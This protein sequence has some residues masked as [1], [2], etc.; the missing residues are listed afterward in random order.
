MIET[1]N[2]AKKFFVSWLLGC[3]DNSWSTRTFESLRFDE[4]GDNTKAMEWHRYQTTIICALFHWKVSI[5][6]YNFDECDFT[7]WYFEFAE[8]LADINPVRVV[9]LIEIVNHIVFYRGG[10]EVY[11]A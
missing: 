6:H 2:G 10:L 1:S 5:N 4:A 8:M 7:V 3:T 11:L 9:I